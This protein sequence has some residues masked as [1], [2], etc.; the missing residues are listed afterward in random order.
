MNQ[1]L[2]NT[3]EIEG[4]RN[5]IS[6]I[7]S[8]GRLP[9]CV[10]FLDRFFR[11]LEELPTEIIAAH[12]DIGYLLNVRWHG[13]KKMFEL[14]RTYPQYL[15]SMTANHDRKL[16]TEILENC[17]DEVAN[18]FNLESLLAAYYLENRERFIVPKGLRT[19][20]ERLHAD[21][22]ARAANH[23]A[24]Y[25]EPSSVFSV[26][27]GEVTREF[28]DFVLEQSA[29]EFPV[30]I[31]GTE[32][33]R[34]LISAG[35]I[36]EVNQ[37]AKNYLSQPDSIFFDTSPARYFKVLSG[38]E[39]GPDTLEGHKDFEEKYRIVDDETCELLRQKF[40]RSFLAREVLTDDPYFLMKFCS[41]RD[42][43]VK[44]FASKAVPK[45][46]GELFQEEM[47]IRA[48]NVPVSYF[49]DPDRNLTSRED[50]LRLLSLA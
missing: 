50:G 43:N 37:I 33:I 10:T 25:R 38:R 16:A 19:A 31:C 22:L 47:F 8:A 13:I 17:F 49:V 11:Q 20:Q 28:V 45:L 3:L 7:V 34:A 21:R 15:E 18:S 14:N 4:V 30:L 46:Y 27:H 44:L 36:E 41:L 35:Y 29:S 26:T 5:I 1:P 6:H 9:N 32:E 23:P 42:S 39:R 12:Q 2:S 40:D 48:A 24:V